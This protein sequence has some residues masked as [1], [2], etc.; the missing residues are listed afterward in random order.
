MRVT[1]KAVNQE[2]ANCGHSVHLV[3]ASGYFYFEGIEAENWLDKTISVQTIS[4]LSIPEWIAEFERLK[5][6]NAE[7]MGKG[8]MRGPKRKS[9][10]SSQ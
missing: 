8:G 3:K 9:S 4:S 2:L 5:K 7:I 10:K 1:V 6:L